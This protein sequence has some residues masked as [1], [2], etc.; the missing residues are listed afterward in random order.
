MST[1]DFSSKRDAAAFTLIEILIVVVLMAILAS[2][3][4]P[5]M[6]DSV[7]GRLRGAAMILARDIQYVQ[8]EALNTGQTLQIQ[9]VSET[10]YQ[11]VDPD[12]G[13]GGT[14]V[15][16]RHPQSDYPA[17]N[18]QFIVDFDDPGPIR[19]VM[20]QSAQFGGQP[21]LEFGPYGEPTASGE[22]VLVDRGHQ[23]RI[24]VSPITGIVGIGNL[25]V[26]P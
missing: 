9:F 2:V 11:V 18:G 1:Y 8:A 24:S 20:I 5:V 22:V 7:P 21:R 15:V 12:G 23:V 4:V 17:H 13:V 14:P 25:E 3:L 6:G 10:Q 19:G 26:A 16:L